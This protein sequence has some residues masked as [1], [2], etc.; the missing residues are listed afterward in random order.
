MMTTTRPRRDLRTWGRRGAAAGATLLLAG[1]AVPALAPAADAGP[2][3]TNGR[4]TYLRWDDQ[5]FAQVWTSNPDLGAEHQLTSGNANS[6]WSVWS[7]D[8][9]RIAFDS[10]RSDPDPTDDDVVNDV[11]TM[12]ADGTDVRKVTDSVGFSGDPAYSPDGTHLAFDANRGVS[13][14]DPGWPA[15]SPDL[16]IWVI[17]TDGTG[18][19]RV[20]RPPAGSSDTEPR[21]SPDGSLISFTRFQGGHLNKHG[22][23]AGDTSAVFVVAADGRGTRRLTGWGL[24]P[25]QTNWAPD[26]SRI[27]FET[28]CCRLGTGNVNAV[29]PWGGAVT[30]LIDGHGFTGIGNETALR[31]DGYYDPVWS[32]DGT[33]LLVGHEYLADDGTFRAGLAVSGADG[34]AV[35][36]ISPQVHDEHQPDWGTA[37]LQ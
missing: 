22:R 29:S 26:G 20:T 28:A 27:V 31:A 3:A 1:L 36:W 35:Q 6:G 33:R 30:T 10:D 13:S 7:P 14:G 19:R 21:F 8:G 34:G 12:R 32:P 2:A 4:L 16:S 18:L 5:G 25:G 37:P 11:F 9:T 23:M 24:K 17:G 15:S